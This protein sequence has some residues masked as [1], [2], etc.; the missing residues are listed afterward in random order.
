VSDDITYDLASQ[1][2]SMLEMKFMLFIDF[3]KKMHG[4]VFLTCADDIELFES[5]GT[6]YQG[7]SLMFQ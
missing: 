2:I 3:P 4:G 5:E 6:L 1:C 7:R